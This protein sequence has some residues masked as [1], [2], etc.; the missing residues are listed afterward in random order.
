[1]EGRI[2][3]GLYAINPATQR[4]KWIAVDGDYHGSIKH[5]C[6]LQWRLEQL[7]VQS[8]LEMS[9]RGGH[10]WTFGAQPLLARDCR[11]FIIGIARRM[12][13]PVKG[14]GSA[15]GIEIFPKHDELKSGE[16]GNAVRGPLGIHR[17]I[18]VRYWFY[19][20]DYDFTGRSAGPSC[21]NWRRGS[22][23]RLAR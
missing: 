3:V 14:S 1:M 13:I 16:Y 20:A 21:R 23:R 12:D 7:G 6:E 15:E 9:R 11:R 8:A 4:S 10:L 17:A 5:L 19:G 2:T 18:G 22:A